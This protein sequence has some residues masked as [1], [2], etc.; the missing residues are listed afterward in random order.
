MAIE[1]GFFDDRAYTAR[2]WADYFSAFVSNGVFAGGLKVEPG[3]GMTV[4]VSPGKAWIGGRYLYNT[5]PYTLAVA[6]ADGAL[7]RRDRI[8]VRL[9]MIA[10]AMTIDI[11]TGTP[12][13][14]PT[15]P[16]LTRTADV[17][18]LC[19][20]EITVT[21]GATTITSGMIADTRSDPNLCGISTGSNDAKTIQGI[22]VSVDG[23]D[24]GKMLGFV[25]GELKPVAGGGGGNTEQALF[26]SFDGDWT[27]QA[28]ASITNPGIDVSG[29]ASFTVSSSTLAGAVATITKLSPVD[30]TGFSTLE[31]SW[32]YGGSITAA[33]TYTAVI[34]IANDIAFTDRI[35]T[36]TPPAPASNLSWQANSPWIGEK[37]VRFRY[38]QVTVPA[39]TVTFRIPNFSLLQGDIVSTKATL[40]PSFVGDWVSGNASSGV[41]VSIITDGTLAYSFPASAVPGDYGEF[42]KQSPIDF[43]SHNVLT[44]AASSGH[45]GILGASA[46]YI[47]DDPGFSQ[48]VASYIYPNSTSWK[49]NATNI[50]GKKYMKIRLEKLNASQGAVS[51]TITSSGLI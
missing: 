39:G 42:Y 29:R 31:F 34:E 32:Q 5:N 43:T 26:P 37:Y 11:V 21:V 10:S 46:V 33:G 35:A 28:D 7:A 8:V 38:T 15:P 4:S 14:L 51:S 17:W 12:N 9:H 19:L 41:T 22:P 48:L 36:Y 49:Y 40:L 45:G 30:F 1:F 13:A 24:N 50:N 2:H 27:V 16:P 25:D 18:E 3:A 44:F 6:Q 47:Y 20:A 23:A